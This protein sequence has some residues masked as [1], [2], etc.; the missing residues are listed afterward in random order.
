MS[1]ESLPGSR[2]IS[3]RRALGI[4]GAVAGGAAVESCSRPKNET[5]APGTGGVKSIKIPDTGAKL[6]AGKVS[7]QWTGS[8]QFSKAFLPAFFKAYH[9]NHPN[10]T[11]NYKNVPDDALNRI[12]QLGFQNGDLP[13]VFRLIG[14]EAG[15][16]A[17]IVKQGLVQPIDDAVP[18]FKSWKAAFP[19]DSFVPGLNVFDGKTYSF[20]ML[21]HFTWVLLF[22]RTYLEQAGVDPVADGLTFDAFRAAA[23]KLTKQGGGSY[24]GLVIDGAETARW[25]VFVDNLGQLAHADGGEFNYKTGR[26]NYTS[27]GFATIVDLLLALKSDKSIDPGS[28]SLN[29]DEARAKLPAG[30]DAMILTETGV[31]PFWI[32]QNPSFKFDITHLPVPSANDHG[33]I[34]S[35]PSTSFWWVSAKT[36]KEKLPVIGDIFSYLGSVDGQKTWQRVSGAGIPV[37]QPAAN[38]VSG[39]DSRLRYAARYF[40]QIV[41]IL[42]APEVRNPDVSL[43]LQEQHPVTPDFGTVVQGIY[44]GQIDN[45]RKAL[46]DLQSRSEKELDRAISVARRKGAKV[47]RDDWVFT[48]WDPSKNYVQSR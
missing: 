24:Y 28:V 9:D 27:E 18:S 47:S 37:V 46:A 42:P 48:D 20:P 23:K 3:R 4:F 21:G 43:V 12:L 5:A 8:S 15:A 17:Q 26:Y 33:Y 34:G 30:Q 19:P 14:A 25:A 38:S 40:K 1:P 13:E 11:V 22:N 2:P 7:L 29:S 31:V 39:I 16:P 45:P 41:R 44:T 35:A 10:I 36:P 32:Q 6:P